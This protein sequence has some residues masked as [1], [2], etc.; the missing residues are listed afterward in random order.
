MS[1]RVALSLDAV[2]LSGYAAMAIFARPWAAFAGFLVL[3]ASIRMG[4]SLLNAL[5]ARRHHEPGVAVRLLASLLVPP[6]IAGLIYVTLFIALWWLGD[7]W[8][9][10]GVLICGCIAYDSLSGLPPGTPV[11]PGKSQDST[12]TG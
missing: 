7:Y 10:I 9:V 12:M 6:A 2:I 5:V 1:R 3:R 4:T 11:Q 8:R